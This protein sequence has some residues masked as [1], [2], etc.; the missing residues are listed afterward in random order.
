MLS[1]RLNLIASSNERILFQLQLTFS[2]D[3]L[4]LGPICA[5]VFRRS[6]ATSRGGGRRRYVMPKTTKAR[7][8]GGALS[9]LRI[10]YELG[11]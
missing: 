1:S 8:V 9:A 5:T 3:V 11:G 4:H 7:L 2:H 10:N 6:D